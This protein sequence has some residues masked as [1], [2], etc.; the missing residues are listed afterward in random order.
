MKNEA[1]SRP[2]AGARQAAIAAGKLL[3]G[4]FFAALILDG[5]LSVV[6]SAR[7]LELQRDHS[8]GPY[9]RFISAFLRLP[10][11]ALRV[12]GA[13]QT[14]ASALLLLKLKRT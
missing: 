9:A 12:I 1:M 6:W 3:G 2:R 7:W 10:E 8:P 14:A 11:P 13:A 5:V 4:I